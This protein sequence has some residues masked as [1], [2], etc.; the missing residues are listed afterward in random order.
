M[1]ISLLKDTPAAKII[2]ICIKPKMSEDYTDDEIPLFN[3]HL[4]WFKIKCRKHTK[5]A[6][7]CMVFYVKNCLINRSEIN[8][9]FFDKNK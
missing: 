2:G 7:I 5:D 4:D 6:G 3:Q 1:T 8:L 9:K